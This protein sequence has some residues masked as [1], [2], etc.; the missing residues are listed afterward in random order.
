[1]DLALRRLHDLKRA[2]LGPFLDKWHTETEFNQALK[3][4]SYE[5]LM[6]FF[7]KLEGKLADLRQQIIS[8]ARPQLHPDST[9]C[10]VYQA[11]PLFSWQTLCPICFRL[12]DDEV[13]HDLEMRG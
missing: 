9:A 13:L 5:Q 6:T 12:P 1:M 4:G 2:T 3:Q 7:E 8:D 11:L 10:L